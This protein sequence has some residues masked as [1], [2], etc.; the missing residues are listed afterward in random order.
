M[1]TCVGDTSALVALSSVRR[2]DLLRAVFPRVLIVPA[3]YREVV[4]QGAGWAQATQL[5]E[6]ISREDW[7]HRCPATSSDQE[8]QLQSELGGTGEAESVAVAVEH[9]FTVLLDELRGRQAARRLGA[10]VIGSLGILQ[11]AKIAGHIPEIRPIIA[12][13]LDNGIYYDDGLLTS[14]F[15]QNGE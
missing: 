2:L 4:T 7:I 13:I 3:V 5:Q 6:E 11:K 10:V 12:D 15:R 14:F 9:Q 1:P 8:Y